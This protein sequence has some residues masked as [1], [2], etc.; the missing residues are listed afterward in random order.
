MAHAEMFDRNDPLL[1]R[2]RTMALAFPGAAEKISHGRPT[3][4]TKKV[5]TYYGGAVRNDDGT[6]TQHPQSILVLL[7]SDERAALLDDPRT[8]VPAYLGPSGWLGVDL[9]LTSDLDEVA[10]LLEG[11][12]RNTAP[13]RLVAELE[14]SGDDLA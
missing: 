9:S 14:D 12:Y 13:M 1:A 2:I 8:F 4:Y 11:S 6:W 3:F 10:E 5:F 7:D